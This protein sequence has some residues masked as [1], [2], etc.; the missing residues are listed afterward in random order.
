[1]TKRMIGAIKN[2]RTNVL[3]HCTGRMV[4]GNRGTRPQSSFDA[5]AVFEACA[6]HDVAVEINSRPERRDPPTKL[7]ELAR[8]IGCLFSIDSDA[9]AP[10]QLDFQRLRLR[11]RPRRRHRPR[12]HRQ[13]LAAR[14][15]AGV[16]QPARCVAVALTCHDWV[17]G[18]NVRTCPGLRGGG[19]PFEAAPPHGLGV[20]RGRPDHRADPGVADPPAGGRVGRDDGGPDR[21]VRAPSPS[22]RR[23]PARAGH[24][25]QRRAT[26]AVSPSRSRC[27]GSTTS[28]PAGVRARRATARSGCPR[29]CRAC[30]RGWSTTCSSTSSRTCWLPVT[31]RRSGRWV[32]RYPARREGQGLPARL[33]RRCPASTTR[34]A[35]RS[36]SRLSVVEVRGPQ[37]SGL[38]SR[39]A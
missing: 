14:S 35:A 25:A 22:H 20:P 18:D 4:M 19:T 32:D 5:R 2:P 30:R 8:D 10:G 21:E 16:G 13:H 27:A 29:D 37:A 31:T 7:L 39:L 34:P 24:R 6:E 17:D 9:H 33:V 15:A 36:T 12:P 26:S 3:G 23:R 11:A 28:A 1:M 38:D